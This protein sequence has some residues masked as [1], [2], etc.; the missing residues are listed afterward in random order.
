MQKEFPNQAL[1]QGLEQCLQDAT[2]HKHIS[3]AQHRTFEKEKTD[4]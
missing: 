2:I 3:Q 1:Q 4:K